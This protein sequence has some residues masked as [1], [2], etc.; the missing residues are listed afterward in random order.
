[1]FDD[2]ITFPV[3]PR[4]IR[5]IR[6]GVYFLVLEGPEKVSFLGQKMSFFSSLGSVSIIV[7]T[8]SAK[9]REPGALRTPKKKRP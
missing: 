9:I 3:L 8:G 1:M 2:I 6:L 4:V 5:L 7:Y